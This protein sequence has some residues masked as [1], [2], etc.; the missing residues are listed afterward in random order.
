[1]LNYIRVFARV[2]VKNIRN[3]R[4]IRNSWLETIANQRS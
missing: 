4:N 1:M 2:R 3:I